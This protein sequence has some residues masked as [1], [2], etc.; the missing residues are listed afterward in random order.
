[1]SQPPGYVNPTHPNHVYLLHKAIYGLKQT[2]R[3]WFDSFTSQQFHIGFQ[4]SSVNCNLFILHHGT[5]VVFF[6]YVDDII[7][8]RNSLPFID[9]LVSRL[10]AT[11]FFLKR[12]WSSYLLSWASS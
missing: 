7:T 9:H 8:T 5:F 2:P 12:S 3:A 6:L 1:M 11:F 10:S 4:A